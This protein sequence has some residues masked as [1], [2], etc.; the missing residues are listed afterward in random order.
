VT[1]DAI[2]GADLV[3]ILPVHD[4]PVASLDAPPYDTAWLPEEVRV[5]DGYVNDGGRVLVVNSAKRLKFYNSA[6]D[7]NEDWADLNLLTSAWGIT[8]T[9]SGGNSSLMDSNAR[10]LF[11]GVSA[12]RLTPGN[13]VA[14][15]VTTGDVLAGN[16]S[17]AYAA[18]VKVGKGEVLILSDL[19]MLGDYENSVLNPRLVEN[20]ANW[21]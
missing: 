13:A 4:Y 17:Q 16:S 1:E 9:E 7:E 14:F 2:S 3:V 11:D 5:I 12:V 8:F 10:K 6:Y 18:Q 21:K 19:T 15:T 20:I